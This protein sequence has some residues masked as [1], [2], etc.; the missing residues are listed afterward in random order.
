MQLS[1]ESWLRKL[2]PEQ[3]RGTS[4]FRDWR[5]IAGKSGQ[6]T[7]VEEGGAPLSSEEMN[8]GDCVINHL[9]TGQH[10]GHRGPG[11]NECQER[12]R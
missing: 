5:E 1:E 4:S 11:K 7:K 8:W 9:A 6:S 3:Q 10:R 2:P 12:E